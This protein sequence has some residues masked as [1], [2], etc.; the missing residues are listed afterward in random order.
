MTKE[1][2]LEV[3]QKLIGNINPVAVASIDRE[4]IENLRLFIAVL[5]EMHTMIDDIAYKWGDTHYGSVKPFV[6]A[7]NAQLNRYRS[8]MKIGNKPRRIK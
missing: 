3:I 4:R 5:D 8:S 6:D 2:I 7:C 1:T